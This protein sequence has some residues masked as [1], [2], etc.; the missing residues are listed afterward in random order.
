HQSDLAADYPWHV[1]FAKSDFL[2]KNPETTKAILKA[3]VE[4]VR[5]MK[6]DRK[7]AAD[8]LMK[9]TKT[10]AEFAAPT[11]D[12]I[13]KYIYEDGRLP[14]EKGMKTFWDIG[15]DSGTYKEAWPKSRYWVD[16]F[17]STYSKWKP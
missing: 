12:L 15:I 10:K 1:F 17:V 5:L 3:F 2:K 4:G 8:V 6:S 9:V 11:V 13:Q 16:D 14:S 7:L